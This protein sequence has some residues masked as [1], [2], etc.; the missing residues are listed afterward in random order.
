MKPATLGGLL[1]SSFLSLLCLVLACALQ[2]EGKNNWY[3]I[4]TIC[5]YMIAIIPL[6]FGSRMA[7]HDSEST[8]CLSFGIFII[9][10]ILTSVIGFPAVLFSAGVITGGAFGL[11]MASAF[12]AGGAFFWVGKKMFAEDDD[13]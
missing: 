2:I 11:T 5:F 9:A 6:I 12:I 7:G 10:V 3:P 4:F 8:A 1:V 13:W